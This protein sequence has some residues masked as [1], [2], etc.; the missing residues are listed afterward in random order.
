MLPVLLALLL[1]GYAQ[2]ALAWPAGANAV[3]TQ[4]LGSDCEDL[5]DIPITYGMQYDLPGSGLPG[6]I[7]DIHD[8]WLSG[9]CVGCHNASNASNAGDL[10]LD[11]PQIGGLSLVNEASNRDPNALRVRPRN[12]EA[13]LLYAQINCT[14]PPTEQFMPPPDGDV[15]VRIPR[16]L[17]AAVY[18]WIAQG[19]RGFDED[20]FPLSD[21]IFRDGHESQRFQRNVALGR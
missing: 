1:G 17:R 21:V 6:P 14:P 13:S 11:D 7:R 4:P 5:S 18:D 8:V 3:S 10:Q 16:V 19:A 2:L 15:L 9:G 20:G 12:P